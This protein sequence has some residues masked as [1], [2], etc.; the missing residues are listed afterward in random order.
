[1]IYD[2]IV[3]VFILLLGIL[4]GFMTYNYFNKSTSYHGPNSN[5]IRKTIFIDK[6]NNKCYTFEPHVYMCPLF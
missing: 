1:M 3:N 2:Y 4:F 5:N 6:K